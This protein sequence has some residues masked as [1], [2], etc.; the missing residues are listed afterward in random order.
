M[1]LPYNTEG[2]A[3]TARSARSENG[4]ARNQL[5]AIFRLPNSPRSL[6][7]PAQRRRRTRI[8]RT[9][10][11]IDGFALVASMPAPVMVLVVLSIVRRGIIGA[12]AV[13]KRAAE[14]KQDQFPFPEAA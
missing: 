2:F 14:K 10:R 1:R 12:R 5:F 9:I 8:T 7:S 3:A 4:S 6:D 13:K 11:T